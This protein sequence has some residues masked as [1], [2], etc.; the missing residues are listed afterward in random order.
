MNLFSHT[1][2]TSMKFSV[3]VA[4]GSG[5]F[6]KHQLQQLKSHYII[7][8]NTLNTYSELSSLQITSDY[9]KI[10]SNFMLQKI[11]KKQAYISFG[12]PQFCLVIE[13]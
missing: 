1:S 12:F 13:I 5:F 7:T 9:F 3:F 10:N 4:Y 2:H 8:L 6:S 11:R